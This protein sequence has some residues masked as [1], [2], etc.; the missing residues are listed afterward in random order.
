MNVL[1]GT[2]CPLSLFKGEGWGE[3]LT[4]NRHAP[5]PNPLPKGARGPVDA[6]SLLRTHLIKLFTPGIKPFRTAQ[7]QPL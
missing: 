5:H 3:G 2:M 6:M 4:P 1:V 7:I